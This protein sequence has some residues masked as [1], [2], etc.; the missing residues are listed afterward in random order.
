[1]LQLQAYDARLPGAIVARLTRQE[2]RVELDLCNTGF[3][4]PDDRLQAM[5]DG[6]IWP[7]SPTLRRVRQLRGSSLGK[8]GTLCISSAIGTGYRATL[9][10]QLTA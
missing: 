9:K 4:M 5:L 6:P 8:D 10:L 7:Q 1:M 3:G 2:Q